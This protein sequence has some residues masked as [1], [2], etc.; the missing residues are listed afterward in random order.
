MENQQP[1]VLDQIVIIFCSLPGL[2]RAKRSISEC[3]HQFFSGEFTV[4]NTYQMIGLLNMLKQAGGDSQHGTIVHMMLNMFPFAASELTMEMRQRPNFHQEWYT[5]CQALHQELLIKT[6]QTKDLRVSPQHHE[7]KVIELVRSVPFSNLFRCHYDFKE[8]DYVDTKLNELRDNSFFDE[9]ALITK[10][11]LNSLLCFRERTFRTPVFQYSEDQWRILLNLLGHQLHGAYMLRKW[12]Q[13]ENALVHLKV[14][15]DWLGIH[16]SNWEWAKINF[17]KA[18]I[19]SGAAYLK[20]KMLLEADREVGEGIVMLKS[21]RSQAKYSTLGSLYYYAA[22]INAER[23]GFDTRRFLHTTV[24]RFFQKSIR[25]AFKSGAV[26]NGIEMSLTRMQ[27]LLACNTY[28]EFVMCENVN[29]VELK[30]CGEQLKALSSHELISGELKNSRTEQLY[31]LTLMNYCIRTRQMEEFQLA[32]DRVMYSRLANVDNRV[33]LQDR[34]IIVTASW[35]KS[36]VPQDEKL[37]YTELVLI[38]GTNETQVLLAITSNG[39]FVVVKKFFIKKTQQLDLQEDKEEVPDDKQTRDKKKVTREVAAL[40]LFKDD[41]QIVQL[42]QCD[43]IS[44]DDEEIYS[45]V[46][47]H[48]NG[49]EQHEKFRNYRPV[50]EKGLA[51]DPDFVSNDLENFIRRHGEANFSR[52][53]V[54]EFILGLAKSLR[55][56]HRRKIVHRDVKPQNFLVRGFQSLVLLVLTIF[57]HIGFPPK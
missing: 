24:D 33:H 12:D 36:P 34:R 21:V 49:D 48:A 4:D 27:Y 42:I 54:L 39:E 22:R 23:G 38:Q 35:I 29:D 17:A 26:K 1:S 9:Y 55:S 3:V 25:L 50:A 2:Q 30:W 13:M 52:Q 18:K 7:S 51:K 44:N 16:H 15:V 20:Q 8:Y 28:T 56:L 57:S 47:E 31:L 14:Q 43:Y 19:M 10:T 11:A 46:L 32:H 53:Q 41:P 5:Y 40:E 37:T 6:S 45:L